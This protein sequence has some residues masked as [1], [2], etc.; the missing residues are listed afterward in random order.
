MKLHHV[1]A[2]AVHLGEMGHLARVTNVHPF[3]IE[4]LPITNVA[5]HGDLWDAS[6]AIF[7]Q[8]GSMNSSIFF[9]WIT[10]RL[11]AV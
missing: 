4:E 7:S 3:V 6:A 2:G 9:Q 1:A 11:P 5:E 10:G 8:F